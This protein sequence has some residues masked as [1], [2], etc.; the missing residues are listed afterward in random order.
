[1]LFRSMIDSEFNEHFNIED[2][3]RLIRNGIYIKGQKYNLCDLQCVNNAIESY[4]KPIY[5]ELKL[6]Y[7]M[8]H[9]PVVLTGGGANLVYRNACKVFNEVILTKD[10]QFSNASGYYRFG[11]NIWS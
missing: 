3:E 1:M 4:M 8:M 11:L 9:M 6:N 5:E 7:N 10:S 2:A